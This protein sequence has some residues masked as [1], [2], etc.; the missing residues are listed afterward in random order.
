VL[1]SFAF[2]TYIAHQDV[3]N[4]IC[5]DLQSVRKEKIQERSGPPDVSRP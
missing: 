4:R 2:E 3:S 1:S 5:Q